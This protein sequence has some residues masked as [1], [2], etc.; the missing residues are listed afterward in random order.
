MLIILSPSKGQ[1]FELAAPTQSYSIAT[2]LNDSI[3]LVRQLKKLSVTEIQNLMSLSDNL[4]KLNWQRYQDFKVPFNPQNAKQALFAFKGD[5]YSGINTSSMTDADFEYAQQHLIILSGLYG[6]LRPLDLIQPYRLEMKTKLANKRGNN[7]YQ[8]WG[9]SI[10]AQLN[11]SLALQQGKMIVNLASNEYW[12]AV[13]QKNLDAPVINIAFK[14]NKDGKSRIIAIFAKKARG[15]MAD[16]IIRN[17]IATL[18]ELKEFNYSKYKFDK[19]AST[20]S[21][22]V[23][24]R[25][26]PA[27]K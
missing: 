19:Q 4:A 17:Q 13:R 12:Q 6:S 7:L 8:F 11:K 18:A 1:D 5:V 26:Q 22:L 14:E 9:N 23:F 24:S 20:A 27:K 2:Q 21:L 3:E 25:K 16:F 10:T 15:M